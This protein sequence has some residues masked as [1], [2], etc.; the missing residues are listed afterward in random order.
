MPSGRSG[1]AKNSPHLRKLVLMPHISR[2][3]EKEASSTTANSKTQRQMKSILDHMSQEGLFNSARQS[4]EMRMP[5]I[6]SKFI[7]I[8]EFSPNGTIKD[9]VGGQKSYVSKRGT[10]ESFA[11]SSPKGPSNLRLVQEASNAS[12][13]SVNPFGSKNHKMVTP[14]ASKMGFNPQASPI[15]ASPISSRDT[16]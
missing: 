10:N 1:V 3:I 12:S 4:G 9:V 13:Y 8:N 2:K 5:Q 11:A 6:G 14:K 15:L 16:L 7:Q